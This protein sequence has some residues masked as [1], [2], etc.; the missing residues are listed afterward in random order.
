VSTLP[1]KINSLSTAENV[2]IV[3]GMVAGWA[4]SVLLCGAIIYGILGVLALGNLTYLQI[5]GLL[6]IWELIKPYSSK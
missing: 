6:V 5:V 4:A 1:S 3:I 2:G